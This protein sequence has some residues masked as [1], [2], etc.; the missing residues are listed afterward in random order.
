MAAL[1]Q[2]AY[3]VIQECEQ[4]TKLIVDTDLFNGVDDAA[5]LLLASTLPCTDL[6]AVQVNYPS[7]YSIL[8][9]SAILTYYSHPDVPIGAIRPFNERIF[10]DTHYYQYGDYASK[11]Q[12]HWNTSLTDA[13]DAWDPVDLYRKFLVSHFIVL[14]VDKYSKLSGLL[15]STADEYSHLDGPELVVS[16]VNELV[17]MGGA[18]PSGWEYNFGG[19]SPALTAHVVNTWPGKITFSGSYL[20]RNVTSGARLTVQAPSMDPVAAAYKWYIGYNTPFYSWDPITLLYAIQ[21]LN[22]FF[23]YANSYG[24]NSVNASD[25][26]NAWVNNT[27]VTNQHW[28]VLRDGFTNTTLRDVLDNLYLS[29]AFRTWVNNVA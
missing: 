9:A 26:S 4:R 19:S 15:N 10:T 17:I 18:Y 1:A 2:P 29:G 25:G 21:G 16:K 27:S 8:T 13:D 24:Y 5:A 11:V 22:N 3:S 7:S 6:L 20:G 14:E 23:E 28:I 12:H